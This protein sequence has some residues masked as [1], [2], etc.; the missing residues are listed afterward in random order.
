LSTVVRGATLAAMPVPLTSPHRPNI[1][2][3]RLYQDWLRD[4]RGLSFDSYDALW[5]W[6]SPSSMPSGRASG[7]TP[8]S[9]RRRRTP[10]CSPSGACPARAGSPAPGQLRAQVLR[11][12]DAAHA[13]GMPAIVSDNEARRGARAVVARAAP[14][15]RGGG[16]HAQVAR[17]AARR[18]RGGLPAQRARDHGRLPGVAR[19]SAPSGACARPTWA[20]AAVPTASA[21]S[22]PRC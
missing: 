14:P 22:N 21:R 19:A 18:P 5:R 8:A 6:S 20:P 15:G 4:H 17:R 9:T 3:I 11:H 12:V 10:P 2:Q 1:P 13:A 7:T 16:A